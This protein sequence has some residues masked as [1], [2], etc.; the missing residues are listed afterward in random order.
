M[1][2]S[3]GL[4]A[5]FDSTPELYH[6]C[7]QVRDAGY[8]RWDAITPFPVHGLDAAMASAA[9]RCRASRSAAA[10]SASPRA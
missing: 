6:A 8:K 9:R 2:K 5:A 1:K 10:S 4:V 7:E 3:Y